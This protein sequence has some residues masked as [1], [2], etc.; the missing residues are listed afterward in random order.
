M[1]FKKWPPRERL[2]WRRG[3]VTGPFRKTWFF[4]SYLTS[5]SEASARLQILCPEF[6]LTS[7]DIV[8]CVLPS[9]ICD[10]LLV[11]FSSTRQHSAPPLLSFTVFL[12]RELLQMRLQSQS[13]IQRNLRTSPEAQRRGRSNWMWEVKGKKEASITLAAC[14]ISAADT[15]HVVPVVRARQSWIAQSLQVMPHLWQRYGSPG[16]ERTLLWGMELC[17]TL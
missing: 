2:R 8:L 10:C 13:A 15:V 17:G 1:L 3:Y 9:R 5:L 4:F 11:F 14:F 16:R 7:V 6:T 12:K